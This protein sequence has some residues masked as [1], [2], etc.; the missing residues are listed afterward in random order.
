MNVDKLKQKPYGVLYWITG[1]PGAGKTTIGNALYY[2]LK[3]Q[4]NNIAI[5]D[6]DIL[7]GIVGNELGY[8]TEDRHERGVRYSKLCKA[9]TDQGIDVVCCTVAMFE[10]I[11]AWNRE[12]NKLYV[13]VF[14]DVSL[15]V[16]QA[17]DQKR[18]V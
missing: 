3:E 14:L 7:K 10:D 5:L 15:E 8:T 16:L 17:R 4:G 12:N 13:E 1:L 9:L 18:Y 11:R 2:R 6:G